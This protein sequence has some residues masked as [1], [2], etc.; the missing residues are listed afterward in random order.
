MAFV[1]SKDLSLDDASDYMRVY[2]ATVNVLANAVVV[3]DARAK[4]DPDE[5]QRALARAQSLEA[6]RDL[7]LLSSELMAF[8]NGEAPV[9]APSAQELAAAQVMA[10]KVADLQAAQAKVEAIVGVVAEALQVFK[11]LNGP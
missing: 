3:F 4:T 5:G 1:P 9:R 2:H 8:L 10:Q 11:A 6:T 7:E